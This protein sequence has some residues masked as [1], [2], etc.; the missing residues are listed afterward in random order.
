MKIPKEI[1]I[2]G[3]KY[4]IKRNFISDDEYGRCDSFTKTINIHPSVTG[5]LLKATFMH[6]VFHALVFELGLRQASFSHD[7]EE[8]LV[9]NLANFVCEKFKLQLK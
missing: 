4:K 7:I 1:S 5:E 3:T 9:E 6:E 2:K 8:V